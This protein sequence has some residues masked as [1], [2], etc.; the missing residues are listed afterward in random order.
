VD[1]ELWD[2]DGDSVVYEERVYG[3]VG[4]VKVRYFEVGSP[5]VAGGEPEVCVSE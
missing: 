5:V 2:V 1:S 3:A 4:A